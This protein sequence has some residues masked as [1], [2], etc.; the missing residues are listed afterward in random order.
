MYQQRDI[1]IKH[2]EAASGHF[3]SLVY[4]ATISVPEQYLTR[5]RAD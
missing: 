5:A 4:Q 3:L 1:Q 2:E